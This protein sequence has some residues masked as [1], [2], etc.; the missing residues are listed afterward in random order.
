MAFSSQQLPAEVYV[1][2]GTIENGPRVSS[3]GFFLIFLVRSGIFRIVVDGQK[4]LSTS[5]ELFV[6]VS[7]EYYQVL[8]SKKVSCYF[9]KVQQ[10][11]IVE[12]KMFY[13]F[14]EAFVSRSPSRLFPDEYDRKVLVHIIKLLVYYYQARTNPV[15]FSLASFTTAASLLVFQAGWQYGNS[16]STNIAYTRKEALTK[17]FVTLLLK[18]YKKEHRV[19]FYAGILCVTEGYLNKS[20][21][22]VTGKTAG[23]CISEILISE[24]KY[25]LIKEDLSIEAIS[26]QLGFSSAGSFSRFFKK[27]VSVSPT[28]YRMENFG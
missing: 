18:H 24:A 19:G 13:H 3:P 25:M 28:A 17:G 2:K 22:E 15:R 7:R 12:T 14:L 23:Q 9:V 27:Q 21:K 5:G 16:E 26:E 8:K 10:Q 20:V 4:V 1:F 11:F 6:A